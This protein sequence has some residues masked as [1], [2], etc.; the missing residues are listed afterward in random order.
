LTQIDI[1]RMPSF[2][3]GFE[4]GEK[5]GEKRGEAQVVRRLLSRHGVAEVSELLDLSPEKVERIA[6]KGGDD[7]LVHNQH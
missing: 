4:R 1:E 5:R 6:A 7:D 2:A 3:I